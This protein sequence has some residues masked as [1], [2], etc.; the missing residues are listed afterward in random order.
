[1]SLESESEVVKAGDPFSMTCRVTHDEKLE[2][3][4]TWLLHDEEL[5][6]NDRVT[7]SVSEE[8][9]GELTGRVMSSISE[10]GDGELTGRVTSS[11]SEEGVGELTFI[12]VFRE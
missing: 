6:M 3:E 8:G 10:E 9:D 7:S 11:I 4:V 2:V 1:M 5:L 12:D